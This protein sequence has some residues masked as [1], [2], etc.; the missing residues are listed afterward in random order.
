MFRDLDR[1]DEAYADLDAVLSAT[2]TTGGG[3]ESALI[4][5]AVN[6]DA[7]E[8]YSSPDSVSHDSYTNLAQDSY[9]TITIK[10]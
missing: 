8:V 3:D 10:Q 9:E 1:G 7:E 5:L 6:F 2:E 4:T